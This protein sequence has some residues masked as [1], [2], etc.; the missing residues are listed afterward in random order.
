MQG[1]LMQ[2]KKTVVS[3]AELPGMTW[4]TCQNPGIR[5]NLNNCTNSIL[6]IKHLLL[7]SLHLHFC[8]VIFEGAIGTSVLNVHWNENI[9]S[10]SF[11]CLRLPTS[12]VTTIFLSFLGLRGK[13]TLLVLKNFLCFLDF[14]VHTNPYFLPIAGVPNSLTAFCFKAGQTRQPFDFKWWN[15][16]LMKLSKF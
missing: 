1:S 4:F 10:S 12:A 15:G 2:L 9:H 13:M 16:L 3:W 7:S 11:T 8:S 5:R 14:Y 6:S